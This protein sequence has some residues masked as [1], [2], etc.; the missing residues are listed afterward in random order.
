[1]SGEGRRFRFTLAMTAGLVLCLLV[2]V[3]ASAITGGH[4]TTTDVVCNPNPISVGAST[5]CSAT[6]IDRAPSGAGVPQG[7]VDFST[8]TAGGVFDPAPSCMLELAGENGSDCHV[9]YTPGTVGTG[10]QQISAMF[11]GDS[12]RDTSSGSTA[13]G[14]TSP[15]SATAP[16]PTPAPSTVPTI[17]KKC[18]KKKHH[19]A[20]AA[21]K[22][23]K[24]KRR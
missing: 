20:A 5:S 24:K 21:K 6:V 13:L 19:R 11:G 16:P 18:K 7:T 1:M 2:P 17:R 4:P 10:T 12:V 14:V 9:T 8:D 15:V 23:K 3:A 22:C